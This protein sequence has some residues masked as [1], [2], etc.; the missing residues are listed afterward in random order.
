M[1]KAGLEELHGKAEGA[2][3]ESKAEQSLCADV[4]EQLGGNVQGEAG[5]RQELPASP[6]SCSIHLS[7]RSTSGGGRLKFLPS[8]AGSAEATRWQGH[9]ADHSS[10]HRQ[11]PLACRQP[12]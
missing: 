7:S 12:L 9:A 3:R 10:L 4:R 2:G 6:P 8:S 5:V 11:G 1:C